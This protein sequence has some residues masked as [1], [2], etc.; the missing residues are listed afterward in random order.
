MNLN[1][2]GIIKQATQMQGIA[3]EQNPN[4]PNNTNNGILC[5]LTFESV[6][7]KVK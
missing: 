5:N 2:E 7:K 4:I 3:Y 1:I 6:C